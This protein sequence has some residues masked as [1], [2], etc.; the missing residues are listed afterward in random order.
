MRHMSSKRSAKTDPRALVCDRIR[1]GCASVV[2]K[3][4]R[5]RTVD[6]N[7]ETVAPDFGR[8]TPVFFDADDPRGGSAQLSTDMHGYIELVAYVEATGRH[9]EQST[10]ARVSRHATPPGLRL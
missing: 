3:G 2:D 1:G 8:I 10:P 4:R 9:N 7:R 6:L 5:K